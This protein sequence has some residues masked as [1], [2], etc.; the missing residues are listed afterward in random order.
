[1][2]TLGT[3]EILVLFEVPNSWKRYT[4]A[5]MVEKLRENN[6]EKAMKYVSFINVDGIADV[7]GVSDYDWDESKRE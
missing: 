3:S 4:T 7:D 5:E 6:G 1:M 2:I